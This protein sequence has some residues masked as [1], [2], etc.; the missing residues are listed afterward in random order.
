[1]VRH[2]LLTVPQLQRCRS[3]RHRSSRLPAASLSDGYRSPARRT[4]RILLL[5]DHQRL[6][7]HVQLRLA[8]LGRGPVGDIGVRQGPTAEPERL[9]RRRSSGRSAARA[10][11]HGGFSMSANDT[12]VPRTPVMQLT[13]PNTGKLQTA[14]LGVGVIALIGAVVL[15]FVGDS[16]FFQS[17]LMA[18]LFWVGLSL[19][20]LVL[21]LVQH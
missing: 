3:R 5:G 19:G 15:G 1:A 18:F 2:L 10:T 21:L 6:R 7:P 14:A 11:R 9:C 17:Y 4:R 13:A 20:A 8:H 12:S 16:A